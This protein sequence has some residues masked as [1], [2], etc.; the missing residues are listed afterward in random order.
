MLISNIT[1]RGKPLFAFSRT[2]G[3]F[4]MALT[5]M[6]GG[7]VLNSISP[8]AAAIAREENNDT[9]VSATIS[10]TTKSAA[11]SSSLGMELLQDLVYQVDEKLVSQ[12]PI[13]QTHAELIV[14]G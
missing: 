9:T 6:A 2:A 14:S 11:T 10:N 13:N 12:I 7:F 1:K 8:I 3:T 4:V 5:L